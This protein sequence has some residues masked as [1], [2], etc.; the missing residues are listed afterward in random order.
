M[1]STRMNKKY[2][3]ENSI[4]RNTPNFS[5]RKPKVQKTALTNE[6]STHEKKKQQK[7]RHLSYITAMHSTT[8]YPRPRS[9]FPPGRLTGSETLEEVEKSPTQDDDVVDV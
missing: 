2:K 9:L 7:Y 4:T 1:Q 6:P 5:K 3:R 8:I